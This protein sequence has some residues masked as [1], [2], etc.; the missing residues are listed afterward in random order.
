MSV[1]I[2]PTSL[3]DLASLVE[4]LNSVF[5]ERRYLA[6]TESIPVGEAMQYHA[7]NITANHP[8][9]SVIDS[10]RVV[11]LCDVVP[12]A[13]PRI[14]AQQHNATLGMLLLPEYRGRGLGRQ[15]LAKTLD[16]ARSKFERIELSV[17]SHNERAH[18][19]YKQV[20]F[21]EEGRRVGAWKLDGITSDIIDM[22]Y[23][24][25]NVAN[26]T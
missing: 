1:I 14:A 25:H 19:L 15:L 13:P 4:C 21:V 12:V 22:V 16:V 17:Y 11:G 23:F 26:R 9:F 5:L 24:T 6:I 20:G 10:D 18:S 7:N 3:N 2:R 8:H